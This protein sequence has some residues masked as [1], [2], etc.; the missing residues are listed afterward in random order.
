MWFRAGEIDKFK[1]VKQ[2]DF[3]RGSRN[4]VV[5][6]TWSVVGVKVLLNTG[7]YL[8]FRLHNILNFGPETIIRRELDP[9]SVV[10]DLSVHRLPEWVRYQINVILGIAIDVEGD[11]DAHSEPICDNIEVDSSWV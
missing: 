3:D 4:S 6:G 2:S 8:E 7:W 10:E 11:K 9:W 5:Q 1:V